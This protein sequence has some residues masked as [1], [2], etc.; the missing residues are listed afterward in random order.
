MKTFLLKIYNWPTLPRDVANVYQKR[1][2]DL[3]WNAV[4]PYFK[5]GTFLDVGCGAGYAMKK[6]KDEF[7]SKVYGIDPQPGQHG[8]GREGSN[9]NID[10]ITIIQATAE[11]IPFEDNTFDVVYSSHVLEHVA[12][13]EKSLN[14]M[15]RVLKDDGVLIIGMPTST[16][17]LI[18]WITSVLFT[19]HQKLVNFFLGGIVTT[20][21]ASFREIFIPNSHSFDDRSLLYDLK[22]YKVKNWK[23]TV[24]S[25]FTVKQTLLPGLYPYPEYRQWFGLIKG[26]RFSSSVFFIGEKKP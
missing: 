25:V 12:S 18:N 3:E 26:S 20:G 14:E 22:H 5:K 8:V 13:E 23:R 2:R 16:M 15:K 7:D 10:D 11:K 19:T 24:E 17:A 9:Y 1:I 4:K 21:K 6:A